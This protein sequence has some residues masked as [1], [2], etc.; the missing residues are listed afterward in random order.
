MD[1]LFATYASSDEEEDQQKP[2]PSSKPSLSL[3]SSLPKPQSS[4]SS[5]SSSLSTPKSSSQIEKQAPNQES[6]TLPPKSSALFSFL[7]PPKSETTPNLPLPTPNNPK[8]VVQFRPPVPNPPSNFDDDDDEDKEDE[9]ERERKKQRQLGQDVSVKSFLTSMPTPKNSGQNSLGALPASLGS[10]RRSIVET[11]G[12]TSVPGSSEVNGVN[13]EVGFDP[14]VGS[15]QQ[16]LV[17]ESY[18]YSYEVGVAG[19]QSQGYANYDAYGGSS[20]DYNSGYQGYDSSNWY[21]GAS[22]EEMASTMPVS[23]VDSFASLGGRRRKDQPPAEIIEVKQDE[24]MKNRPTEDKSKLTGI[25]FGPSYQPAS[26]KGKPSKQHK[27]KHQI[28]ALYFDMKQKEME[29]SE[30][31]AKGFLT[32][33]ETQAKY[34]W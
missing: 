15:N 26:T 13:S 33:A 22:A 5:S 21:N 29:L 17:G 31:R 24:L 16:N 1:S 2:Q 34:G 28:S 20:S 4:A 10:G 30:R 3:F 27:R 14:N 23:G 18:N 8:R 11:E 7:P 9:E 25:P 6:S 12:P 32:K 19:D